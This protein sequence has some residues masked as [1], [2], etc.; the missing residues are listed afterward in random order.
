MRPS[1][2]V[3]AKLTTIQSMP[4]AI[5][6]A[7]RPRSTRVKAKITTTSTAKKVMV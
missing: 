6:P 3:P 5:G 7:G 2:S 4:P 1:P